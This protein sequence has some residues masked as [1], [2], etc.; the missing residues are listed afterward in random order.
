[1]G[2]LSGSCENDA[3]THVRT[4]ADTYVCAHVHIQLYV[5]WAHA[6]ACMGIH[7]RACACMCV[8]VCVYMYIYVCESVHVIDCSCVIGIS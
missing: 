5:G 1:M 8:H 6:S 4:P 3:C 2:P 7:V